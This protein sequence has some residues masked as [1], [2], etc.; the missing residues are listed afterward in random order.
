MT[1]TP[2]RAATFRPRDGL[3][4]RRRAGPIRVP[5]AGRAAAPGETAARWSHASA[6][7]VSDR[8]HDDQEGGGEDADLVGEGQPLED[9]GAER[10]AP[11]QRGQRRGRDDRDRRDADAG[12]DTGS[13]TGTSTRPSTWSSRIPIPRPASRSSGSTSLMPA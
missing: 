8:E 2:F 1:C 5:S 4:K 7:S 11:D 13:A 6:S 9:E 10:A 12:E 3:R